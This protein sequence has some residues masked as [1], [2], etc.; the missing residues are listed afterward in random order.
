MRSTLAVTG[1]LSSLLRPLAAG[2]LTRSNEGP[3]CRTLASCS[4]VLEG[5]YAASFFF[6]RSIASTASSVE[7][8]AL[9]KKP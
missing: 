1:N 5:A 6:S 3:A 2:S 9:A 7:S 8:T 4:L